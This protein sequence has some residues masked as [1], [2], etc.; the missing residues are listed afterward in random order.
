MRIRGIEVQD[1]V[2]DDIRPGKYFLIRVVYNNQNGREVYRLA[3][4]PGRTNQSHEQRLE[5]WLGETNNVSRHAEGAVEMYRDK[6]GR[7][8]YRKADAQ[9]LLDEVNPDLEIEEP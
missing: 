2:D 5:G 6:D 3:A 1:D 7:M 9:A 4:E 8:R